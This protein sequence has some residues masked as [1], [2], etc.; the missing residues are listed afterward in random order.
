MLSIHQALLWQGHLKQF[1]H[2]FVYLNI[3]PKLTFYFDQSL[4][5]IDPYMFTGDEQLVFR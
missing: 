1:I 4:D 2:I 5:N 3:N